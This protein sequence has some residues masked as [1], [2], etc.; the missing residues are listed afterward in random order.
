MGKNRTGSKIKKIEE[1]I[2][3]CLVIG[4]EKVCG[5]KLKY[6]GYAHAN[7]KQEIRYLERY[8]R[9]EAYFCIYCRGY[10]LGKP[11]GNSKKHILDEFE[12]KK[13]FYTNE[14]KKLGIYISF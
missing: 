10:H 13:E 9:K 14:L 12:S 1:D 4:K 7:N 11:L 3:I 6:K 8:G 2:K 5:N